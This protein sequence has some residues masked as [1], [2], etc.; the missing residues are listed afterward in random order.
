MHPLGKGAITRLGKHWQGR[1]GKQRAQATAAKA[2]DCGTP[3]YCC[4]G[5]AASA[6]KRK[7]AHLANRVK[8]RQKGAPAPP[9]QPGGPALPQPRGR[10]SPAPSAGAAPSAAP[11]KAPPLPPPPQ[12]QPPR[13]APPRWR[14]APPPRPVTGARLEPLGRPL[15]GRWSCLEQRPGACGWRRGEEGRCRARPGGPGEPLRGDGGLRALEGSGCGRWKRCG[16]WSRGR[17]GKPVAILEMLRERGRTPRLEPRRGSAPPGR[18]GEGAGARPEGGS[19]LSGCTLRWRW[20]SRR[21]W[22]GPQLRCQTAGRAGDRL[23]REFPSAGPAVAL[24]GSSG[25]CRCVTSFTV[26]S[27][28]SK[29]S[30]PGTEKPPFL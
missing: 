2:T 21:F 4:R 10:R 12:L 17:R 26:M 23:A 5:G 16:P 6:K 7:A 8:T 1:R 28:H 14:V 22:A 3:A 18:A 25:R 27:D 11:L 13:W 30:L 29:I 24:W 9:P 19:A 15:N 20:L